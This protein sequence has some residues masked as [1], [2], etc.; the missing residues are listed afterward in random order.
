LTGTLSS[1]EAE[2]YGGLPQF[3]YEGKAAD[4]VGF[5]LN[6]KPSLDVAAVWY[7][8]SSGELLTAA[9]QSW[10]VDR[11]ELVEVVMDPSPLCPECGD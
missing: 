5:A 11:T 9:Q 8:P 7:R 6:L 1:Q 2:F 4:Y 10:P 3:P